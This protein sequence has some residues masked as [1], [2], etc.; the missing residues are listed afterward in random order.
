MNPTLFN[1]FAIPLVT[2][3]C[4]TLVRLRDRSGRAT[5]EQGVTTV[6]AGPRA[7]AGEGV[8]AG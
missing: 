6:G 1:T 7:T 3:G 8:A 4:V 2:L 5:P